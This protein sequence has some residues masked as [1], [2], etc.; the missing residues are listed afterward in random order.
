[1]STG[2]FSCTVY[3]ADGG[4]VYNLKQNTVSNEIILTI[5]QLK[6]G[7]YFIQITDQ[8]G[9]IITQKLVVE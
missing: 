9:K 2:I 7:I 6:S 5:E 3:T 4:A 1:N 8:R